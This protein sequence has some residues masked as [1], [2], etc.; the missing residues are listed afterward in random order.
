VEA[1]RTELAEI[2][3]ADVTLG[4]S[5][6]PTL[7]IVVAFGDGSSQNTMYGVPAAIGTKAAQVMRLCG[8]KRLSD[9]A[10]KYVRVRHTSTRIA[11]FWHP[12]KDDRVV[13]F[14]EPKEETP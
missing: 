1:Y 7:E 10:G 3:R 8:V 5:T 4:R 12:L 11:A 13:W 14:L 9:L 6:F 2:D